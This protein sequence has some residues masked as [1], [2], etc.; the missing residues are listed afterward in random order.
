MIRP[1]ILLSAA[2]CVNF[3][4]VSAIPL[5]EHLARRRSRSGGSVSTTTGSTSGEPRVQL[6]ARASSG[7]IREL[8]LTDTVWYGVFSLRARFRV[9]YLVPTP[10]HL[11]PA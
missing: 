5:G 1:C 8:S 11:S 6:F 10:Q 9:R 4:A 3:S 7:L 2:G